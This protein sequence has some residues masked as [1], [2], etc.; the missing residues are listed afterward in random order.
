MNVQNL[1][2]EAAIQVIF[3]YIEYRIAQEIQS[4]GEHNAHPEDFPSLYR[5]LVRNAWWEHFR[6]EPY[7]GPWL[8]GKGARQ[9]PESRD[10]DEWSVKLTLV[11]GRILFNGAGD[12]RPTAP[13]PITTETR[14]HELEVYTQKLSSFCDDEFAIPA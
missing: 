7:P 12:R 11:K 4:E 3:N 14:Q 6:Y 1:R 13:A 8:D 2:G 9:L 10:L 5:E